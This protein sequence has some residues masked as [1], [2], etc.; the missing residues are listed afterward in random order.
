[1]I[2]GLRVLTLCRALSMYCKRLHVLGFVLLL[3]LLSLNAFSRASAEANAPEEQEPSRPE[4]ICGTIAAAARTNGLPV[5]FFA[6]LI[7]QESRFQPHEVGPVT[8]TGERAQ[9]IAQ[10]MP[11]TAAERHLL[12]PFNPV[13]A[14]LKSAS[15]L[16]ELRDKFGNLGL[17]AAAYNA[18]PQRVRDFLAGSRSL[19]AETR[20]YVRA[21]TGNLIEDWAKPARVRSDDGNIG[22]VLADRSVQSCLD[23]LTVLKQPPYSLVKQP[24]YP[25]VTRRLLNIN[26]AAI[27]SSEIQIE[28]NPRVPTWCQHLH[29]PSNKVCG[30]VHEPESQIKIS[31]NIKFKLH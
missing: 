30:T 17:A 2:R 7:W 19:P 5:D 20:N 28:H 21:I 29:H 11:G 13:E 23:A 4:T 10:F 31:S 1:M 16:A 18:G 8:R 25:L 6:R 3:S 22:E 12:D 15:L 9:G 27:S 24:P 26:S 14:L